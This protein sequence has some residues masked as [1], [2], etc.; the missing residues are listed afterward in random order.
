VGSNRGQ[1]GLG[2]QVTGTLAVMQGKTFLACVS[3]A[4]AAWSQGGF[5]GGAD[6]KGDALMW[7]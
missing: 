2:A 1:S 6:G 5:D 4:G 3:S 7:I